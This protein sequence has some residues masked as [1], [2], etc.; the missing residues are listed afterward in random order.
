M[1]GQQIFELFLDGAY[2][3]DDKLFHSSFKKGYRKI[4]FGNVS[5]DC[6]IG[7]LLKAGKFSSENGIIKSN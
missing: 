5:L 4:R 1:N 2:H 3:Q 6:A 7:K